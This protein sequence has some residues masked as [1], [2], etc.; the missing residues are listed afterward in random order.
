MLAFPK[1]IKQSPF[2]FVS[3]LTVLIVFTV[4]L[5]PAYIHIVEW[6]FFHT[7]YVTLQ[8]MA[9]SASCQIP[10]PN[11]FDDSVMRYVVKKDP[12]KCKFVQPE[13]TYVD[14]EGVLRLN[15][16]AMAA[17]RIDE[18]LLYCNYSTLRRKPNDDDR[19]IYDPEKIL[20]VS[21]K[22]SDEREYVN[23]SC[24]YKEK[25]I[26]QNYHSYIRKKPAV[27]LVDIKKYKPQVFIFVIESMS[28]LNMIRHMPKTYSYLTDVMKVETLKGLTKVAD[29]SFPNMIALLTG[30]KV[31][32]VPQELPGNESAGPYDHWPFIWKNFKKE[33]Y[34]T[35]LTEDEPEYT[36]LNY[37]SKGCLRKPTDYYPR[38]LWLALSESSLLKKSSTYC[39][40]NIPTYTILFNWMKEFIEKYS[41][42]LYFLFSFYI[43]VTHTNFNNAQYLD[44]DVY[45]LL[46]E[47]NENG[48]FRNT[49]VIVMG[50]HG[51]RY[52]KV[53]TTSIGRIEERMPLF[54]IS[55][56]SA[57][58]ERF[59]HLRKYL[60]LN[61]DRLTTWL[62]VH[63]MLMDVV[64]STYEESPPTHVWNTR[65]YSAWRM[66]IPINR[67][68][69]TAGIAENHCVCQSEAVISADDPRCLEASIILV[70]HLNQLL[71][72]FKLFCEKLRLI[73]TLQ[74]SV[75]LPW[76]HL[77]QKEGYELKMRLLVSLAPS[78]AVV[79]ALVQKTAWSKQFRVV[80]DVS[81]LNK[82]GN[83]S[84]CIQDRELR[85]FCYCKSEFTK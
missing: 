35:A 47:L 10:T 75:I 15:R 51:N 67:T 40:G 30:R 23:V 82:Y 32:M 2:R 44:G 48:H 60:K 42:E 57:L 53:L 85:K 61:S 62:D 64:K 83:Q 45:N 25:A 19:V 20:N 59:P 21:A 70:E 54:S 63:S 71:D 80:G 8:S 6:Q 29:N 5:W 77:V 12:L 31:R 1:M 56:P 55:I 3:I 66:E 58:E 4:L 79:E 39:L 73:K 81:R 50:D 38:P 9:S 13:L 41:R 11:A 16:S 37:L 7:H 72:D 78:D 52:G 65:G 28:R 68:C 26:Y 43:A 49:V 22:I 17:H 34:V 36:I 14:Y 18:S 46:R 24:S 69:E 76:K 74:A 33:G 84:S 27:K